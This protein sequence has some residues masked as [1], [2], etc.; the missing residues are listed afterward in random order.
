VLSDAA[1]TP[2]VGPDDQPALPNV[3]DVYMLSP[4]LLGSLSAA[5]PDCPVVVIEVP[6]LSRARI[7]V[8]RR[9]RDV[10]AA[11]IPHGV[12]LQL[13]LRHPGVW[14]TP[15]TVEK[16][17]W[18]PQSARWRGKLETVVLNEVLERFL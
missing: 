10:I 14:C 18:T 16:S 2:P 13:G 15:L 8:V 17:L 4:E 3:G 12:A 9:T 6:L 5:E 1:C 11:G 7:T